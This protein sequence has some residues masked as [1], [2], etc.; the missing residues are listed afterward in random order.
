MAHNG[1]CWSSEEG[2]KL[3]EFPNAGSN[4]DHVVQIVRREEGE[5]ETNMEEVKLNVSKLVLV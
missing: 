3:F 2:H 5:L 1:E 4:Q